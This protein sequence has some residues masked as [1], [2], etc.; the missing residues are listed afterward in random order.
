M[1]VDRISVDIRQTIDVGNYENITPVVSMSAS[2]EKDDD[3]NECFS[4][5][6]KMA[7]DSWARNA[8]KELTWVAKRKTGDK[9]HELNVNTSDTRSQIKSLINRGDK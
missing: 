1:K 4:E 6:H 5:L 3:I 9:Q 8:L 2:L 7:S